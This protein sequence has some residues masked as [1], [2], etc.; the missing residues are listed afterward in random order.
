[1]RRVRILSVARSE[2]VRSWGVLAYERG[3]RLERVEVKKGGVGIRR[4][5]L[6]CNPILEREPDLGVEVGE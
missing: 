3:K 5:G 2:G 6:L 4:W 1:M